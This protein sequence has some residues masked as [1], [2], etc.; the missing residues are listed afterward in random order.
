MN[1]LIDNWM[2]LVVLICMVYLT[3]ASTKGFA[4]KPTDE[5]IKEIKKWLLIA[6]TQCEAQLGGKTGRLKLSLCY[7]MFVKAMP[8]L[9]SIVSFET[10]SGL[11]DEVLEEMKDIL[12]NQPEVLDK[13]NA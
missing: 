10:F 4:D 11:V 3:F 8:A 7:D 12:A 1:W 6:V 2:L 5:Q 13:V 9:A